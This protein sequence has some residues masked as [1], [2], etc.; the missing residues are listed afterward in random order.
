M[1]KEGGKKGSW[2]ITKGKN[3]RITY[4]LN[5]EKGKGFLYLLKLD[6]NILAF[7]DAHGNLLVGDLDFS[8]ML[9]KRSPVIS[10]Q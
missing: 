8:Y 5:D 1:R 7:T 3:G 6:E 2:E 9:N 4:Q 10:K